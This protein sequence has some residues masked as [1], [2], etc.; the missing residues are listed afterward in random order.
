LSGLFFGARATL[1]A[2]R[3]PISVQWFEP[4]VLPTDVKGLTYVNLVGKTWPNVA[5]QV[6][7][8]SI[9]VIQ[10]ADPKNK[11]RPRVAETLVKSEA[12]GY[13]RLKLYMPNGLSQV[14]ISFRKDNGEQNS[15][16]LTMRVDPNDASLNVKV[17]RPTKT[18]IVKVMEK[19]PVQFS[20]GMGLA[21]LNFS[22]KLSPTGLSDLKLQQTSLQALR[23]E[24]SIK[25]IKWWWLLQYEMATFQT[26]SSLDDRTVRSGNTNL[27]AALIGG[28]YRLNNAENEL[29]ASVDVDARFF[30]LMTV[31]TSNEV[32]FVDTKIFRLGLGLSYLIKSEKFDTST[33]LFYREPISIKVGNGEL[34]YASKYT[35]SLQAKMNYHLN[36]S[37]RIGA[38]AEAEITTFNFEY[39]NSPALT[40]NKGTGSFNVFQILA[41]VQYWFGGEKKKDANLPATP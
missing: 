3:D 37:W 6:N 7:P 29:W 4:K 17:I 39:L 8:D 26:P 16:L 14:P 40:S 10:P 15:I 22:E 23:L 12:R 27:Q 20:V 35:A 21:P 36:D 5:I 11:E 30:P 9:I 24:S 34:T 28:R 2:D 1:A 31:N 38:G 25:S 19:P 33:S 32:N 41:N 18:K 13:F